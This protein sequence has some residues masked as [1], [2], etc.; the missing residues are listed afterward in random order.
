MCV[1]DVIHQLYWYVRVGV[2]V[3]RVS[4]HSYSKIQ[5]LL[6]DIFSVADISRYVLNEECISMLLEI[7]RASSAISYKSRDSEITSAGCLFVLFWNLLRGVVYSWHSERRWFSFSMVRMDSFIS[8][9]SQ[10]R[11]SRG[12]FGVSYLPRSI[13][14]LCEL[15]LSLVSAYRCEKSVILR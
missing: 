4:G 3:S 9:K 8:Q 2:C 11:S 7:K 14:R 5:L 13:F 6:R 12:V 10:V 1:R 15:V